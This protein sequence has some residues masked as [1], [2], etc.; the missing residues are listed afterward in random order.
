MFWSSVELRQTLPILLPKT[1]RTVCQREVTLLL[2]WHF[3]P[4]IYAPARSPIWQRLKTW[5]DAVWTAKKD[6]VDN[7]LSDTGAIDSVS[8]WLRRT[9]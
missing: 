6:S 7:A 2:H 5:I 1:S 8:G 9:Q 3:I 4:A